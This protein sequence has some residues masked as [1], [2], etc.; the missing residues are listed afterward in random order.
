MRAPILCALAP[1]VLSA[2]AFAACSRSRVP[3]PTYGEHPKGATEAVCVPYPPPAGKPEET[4]E[5]PTARAV[6][7]DGDWIWKP[8]GG[9]TSVKGKWEWKPGSWVEPPYGATFAR[10]S[11]VR[12]PNG[13][14]AVYP[15]HWHTTEHYDLRSDAVGPMASSGLALT[16][17]DPPKNEA[18]PPLV[19]AGDAHVG[20]ALMYPADAPATTP[21]KVVTDA[22][23]PTDTK[24]PPKLIAPPE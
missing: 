17:P 1:C 15:A 3:E 23:V 22:V 4:G 7:V 16:C 6:W 21:P 10:S 14:L 5:P 19:D 8:L 9:P 11:L 13:A 12:M 24:E 20:P 2:I 18:I